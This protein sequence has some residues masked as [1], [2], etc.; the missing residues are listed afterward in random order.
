MPVFDDT[1]LVCG[2]AGENFVGDGAKDATRI[3][4]DGCGITSEGR[5]HFAELGYRA[6]IFS[7]QTA[8]AGTTVVA[9]NVTPVNGA[10]ASILSLYN[11]LNSGVN[12]EL[13]KTIVHTI[14]GTPG[15]GALVYNIAFLQNITAGN[16]SNNGTGTTPSN[17]LACGIRGGKCRIFT[18]LTLA[19]AVGAERLLRPIGGVFA[20]VVAGNTYGNNIVDYPDGDIVLPPGGLLTI[21]A[22]AIGTT[23]VITAEFTW[24]EIPLT[25]PSGP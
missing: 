24:A 13:I 9:A 2:E 7:G 15:A 19:G 12:A 17:S 5:G 18:Q 4:R 22:P 10:V 23:W 8:N 20:G 21:A 25:S 1:A 11:P 14:S 3:G 16:N 6:Q